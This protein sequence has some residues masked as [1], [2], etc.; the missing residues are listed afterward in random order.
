LIGIGAASFLGLLIWFAI[1]LFLGAKFKWAAIGIGALIG[2]T[3]HWLGKQKSQAL[4]IAASA[5]TALVMVIGVLWSA[6]HE[7]YQA[8]NE[9]LDEMWEEQVAYAKEAVNASRTDDQLSAFLQKNG[10]GPG[11]IELDEEDGED[12]APFLQVSASGSGAVDAK[13]LSDFRK[14][15]LPKLRKFAEGKVS[16]GQF[17]RE[18]RPALETIFTAGFIFASAFRV[19]MLVLIGLAIGAAW[20]FSGAA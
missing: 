3:G 5:A 19:K 4:G 10:F 18:N 17:E 15:E 20:K 13:A 7:A 1:T 12:E 2:W 6:R 16:K 9:T 14:T 11:E 8:V